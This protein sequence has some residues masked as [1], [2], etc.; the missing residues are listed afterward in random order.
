MKKQSRI[1]ILAGLALLIPAVA[2]A[3]IQVTLWDFMSGGDGVRWKQ[4]IKDFNESQDAIRVNS[5]TLTWGDPFYTKVHTAVVSGQTPDVMTYHISH[6]PAGLKAND[7]RPITEAELNSVGLSFKDFNPA[8]VAKS[9]EIGDM[10]G[11]PGNLYGIPLDTHTSILYYNKDI[12]RKA[13]LLGANGLPKDITGID[14]FTAA[15]QKIKDM[16][17]DLP[18]ALSSSQDPATVW[19]LFYTLFSQQGG[20]F[21][22]NGKFSLDQLDTVGTKTLQTMVDWTS[23]GYI[24]TAASYAAAIALF[25]SGKAAFMMNG[26]WEVTTMVDLKKSG[27]P[28]F[29][30]GVMAFPQLYDNRLTWADS[31][32]ICI[33]TNTRHP[34]TAEKLHA[35]LTFVAYVEKHSIIW[36]GSGHIPAYLPVLNS[37]AMAKLVPNNEC[38][39]QAAKDVCFEP[40]STVFGV[41]TP[42]M[43]YVDNFFFPALSGKLSVADAISNFKNS[44][45]SAIR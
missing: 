24:P 37:P 2:F 25:S 20:T 14:D 34:I 11:V 33:P 41:G 29:D 12:L 3:Q 28:P 17:G 38:A 40:I 19:R 36:A 15:L 39:S 42:A 4:I 13:G 22:P 23:K 35:V 7:L 16:T 30:Y 31:H 1:A 26:D 18:M 6:F 32:E 10:F 9:K 5:T 45:Q 27:K 21:T 8:L 44:I 43:D